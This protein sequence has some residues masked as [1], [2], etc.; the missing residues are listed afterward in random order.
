LHY[1]II[2]PLSPPPSSSYSSTPTQSRTVSHHLSIS[3]TLPAYF[4]LNIFT[5]TSSSISSSPSNHP[6]PIHTY[7]MTFCSCQLKHYHVLH[8]SLVKVVLP[9]LSETICFTEAKWHPRWE[10]SD[11]KGE[12]DVLI[13]KLT[14]SLVFFFFF[15]SLYECYK[16]WLVAKGIIN[17]RVLNLTTHE[18]LIM[19]CKEIYLFYSGFFYTLLL[20]HPRNAFFYFYFLSIAFIRSGLSWFEKILEKCKIGGAVGLI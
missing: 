1:S 7:P 9:S 12:I 2:G 6:P 18:F 8:L 5:D 20:Q 16:A 10:I 15:L 3:R 11:D 13:C 19:Q 14:S 4:G 17:K